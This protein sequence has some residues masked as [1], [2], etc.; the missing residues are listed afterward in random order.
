MKIC[1]R[2][3]CTNIATSGDYCDEHKEFGLKYETTKIEA[4][5]RANLDRLY[6]L[7]TNAD[8]RINDKFRQTYEWQKLREEVLRNGQCQVCGAT[9][10]L[11]VH[12]VIKPNGNP[13]L[14]FDKA[15]LMILCHKCHV[16]IHA[17]QT[18]RG[19]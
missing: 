1:K 19:Y 5:E 11:E 9:S 10:N 2:H 14:F 18:A 4:H 17:Q 7:F 13:E 12:H 15:N 6:K 16:K 8:K 3:G